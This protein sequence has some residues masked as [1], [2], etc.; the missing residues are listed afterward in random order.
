ML[1]H[2]GVLGPFSHQTRYTDYELDFCVKH[3][4]H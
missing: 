3:F 2:F 4:G 1:A